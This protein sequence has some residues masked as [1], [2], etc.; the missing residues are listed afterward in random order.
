MT[1]INLPAVIEETKTS[2]ALITQALGV[3]RDILNSDEEIEAAWANLPRVFKKIPAYLRT[4]SL[5]RMCVA[6]QAGLFDSAINYVWNAAILELREKV[7]RFG[8]NVVRQ[9]IAKNVIDEQAFLDLKDAELLDL[10]LKLNLINEDGYFFLDQCKDIRN[11]FS[12]AHPVVGKI[13][14]NELIAFINRCAKYAIG[15]EH[16][17]VGVDIQAFITAIKAAKFTP[18]QLEQW[19]QR[20]NRTHEAQRE[21]L[22]V[23]IHGIYCDPASSEESR[24]NA[25]SIANEFATN[26][27]PKTISDLIDRHQEYLAKGDSFRHKASQQFFEKLGLLGLLSES[28]RH[29]LISNACKKLLSVHQAFDNFYNEPPFAERLDQITSQGSIPDTIKPELVETVVTYAVGNR[30]GTSHAAY[31]FYANIIKNLSP[32]EVA[33]MLELPVKNTGVAKRIRAYTRCKEAFKQIVA[34]ID[35]N[36]VPTKSKKT[37]QEWLGE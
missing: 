20:L 7:R 15:D 27:T 31:P 16:N 10:C 19:T 25:L 3:P 12:A 23:M 13:D 36:S 26:F 4:E 33:L 18:E 1:E 9:I 17:P 11:N 14:D 6:V 5:V 22:F 34:L 30:F 35:I 8:L 21:L 37:F 29:S 28:E 2:I 24:L 32:G